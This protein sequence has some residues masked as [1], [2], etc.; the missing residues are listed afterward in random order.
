[1]RL[2]RQ[3]GSDRRK[4]CNAVVFGGPLQEVLRAYRSFRIQHRAASGRSS[5]PFGCLSRGSERPAPDRRRPRADALL[6]ELPQVGVCVADH[7]VLRADVAHHA[8][9]ARV[10]RGRERVVNEQAQQLVPRVRPPAARAPDALQPRAAHQRAGI[11]LDLVGLVGRI[12]DE[13]T[14]VLLVR[15]RAWSRTGSPWHA[16]AILK[17][18]RRS[19]SKAC[20]TLSTLAVR[21]FRAR[22]AGSRLWMP[23][24]TLVQ[25]KRRSSVRLSGVTASG[26]VS[27]TRPTQ[28]CRACSLAACCA[29]TS[30]S[31]ARCR[32]AT[33]CHDASFWYSWRTARLYVERAVAHLLLRGRHVCGGVFGAVGD[34]VRPVERAAFL[35]RR[36]ALRRRPRRSGRGTA[37]ARTRPGSPAGSRSTCRPAR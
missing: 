30:S 31:M 8:R 17:P 21:L 19:S 28:R 24:C 20:R 3:G 10:A 35:R 32:A 26:R 14:V 36:G 27:T 12:G 33:A 16:R 9:D 18:N 37:R 29:A 4:P 15:V 22:T 6:H 5:P 25:P 11:E 1:M 2:G 13:A 34:A 23:I 7:D